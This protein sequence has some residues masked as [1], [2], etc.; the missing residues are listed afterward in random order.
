MAS[1]TGNIIE[2]NDSIFSVFFVVVI[3]TRSCLGARCIQLGNFLVFFQIN[4][5]MVIVQIVNT[6]P[7]ATP[8][9]PIDQVSW[10]GGIEII[11]VANPP[12]IIKPIMPALNR[13]A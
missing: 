2:L 11:T 5:E 12:T 3:T 13:P 6:K 4:V 1:I 9:P 10:T 8:I 7:K